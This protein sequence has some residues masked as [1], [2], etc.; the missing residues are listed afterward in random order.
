MGQFFGIEEIKL[1]SKASQTTVTWAAG[2]TLRIGGQGYTIDSVLTMDLATDIDT[3][4]VAIDTKYYIYAVAVAGV[5]SLKYSL[6][7]SAP[8]GYNAYRK[9]GDMLTDATP[10]ISEVNDSSKVTEIKDVEV[11]PINFFS[12][13]SDFSTISHLIYTFPYD[14]EFVSDLGMGWSSN[15]SGSYGYFIANGDVPQSAVYY[16]SNQDSIYGGGSIDDIGKVYY[17]GSA[18]AGDTL[19]VVMGRPSVGNSNN[20]RVYGNVVLIRK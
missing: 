1:I 17:S 3:G 15:V 8:T 6:S 10:E 11:I 7:D 4:A 5:V 2:S 12:G 16:Y 18:K 14:C 20:R 9:L 13:Y 19:T